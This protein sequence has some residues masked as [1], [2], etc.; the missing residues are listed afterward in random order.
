ML[1][2][3]EAQCAYEHL[4]H[5]CRLFDG[6]REWQLG[7][8]TSHIMGLMTTMYVIGN[9]EPPVEPALWHDD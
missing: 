3:P 8:M 7:A 4:Q 1:T 5:A 6:A 9:D 2:T